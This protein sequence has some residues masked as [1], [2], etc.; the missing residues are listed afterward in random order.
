MVNLSEN[1]SRRMITIFVISLLIPF[2]MVVA[3]F[4]IMGV[5]EY[6]YPIVL[7]IFFFTGLTIFVI[8]GC[9]ITLVRKT[10]SSVITPSTYTQRVIRPTTHQIESFY[11]IPK[12]CPEC[13]NELHLSRVEWRDDYTIVCPSC[14]E[15][16]AVGS[17]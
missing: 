3:I 17:F 4:E 8:F 13:S 11:R 6:V 9:T 14:F 16:V 1:F 5:G 10:S 15:D 12:N 7:P 2:V